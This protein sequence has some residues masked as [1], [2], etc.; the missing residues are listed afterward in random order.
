MIGVKTS[1]VNTMEF[2]QQP[3]YYED[4]LVITSLA[5]RSSTPTNNQFH[6]HILCIQ[7]LQQWHSNIM[8]YC[9]HLITTFNSMLIHLW[10]RTICFKTILLDWQPFE[11]SRNKIEQDRLKS[12]IAKCNRENGTPWNEKLAAVPDADPVFAGGGD[13]E[14]VQWEPIT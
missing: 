10:R 13:M 4:V 7:H 3:M 14:S 12:P 8:T 6:N 11:L 2:I 5:C 1:R 9:L